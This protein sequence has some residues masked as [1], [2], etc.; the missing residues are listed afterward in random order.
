MRSN[1]GKIVKTKTGKSNLD[2][3]RSY[4]SGERAFTQVG[5]DQ[6]TEL[7][8]RKEGEEWEDSQGCKWIKKNGYKQR[9]SKKAQYILEQRCTV[10]NADVKWGNRLDHKVYPK[11]QRCYECN[12]EFEGILRNQGLYNDYELFKVINNKLAQLKDFKDK[13]IDSINFLENHKVQPKDPQFFNE[14]GSNEIWIDDTDRIEIVLKDLR[15]DLEKT[16]EAINLESSELSKLNYNT[17]LDPKIKLLTLKKI[18]E[19]EDT[20]NG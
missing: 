3:V 19:K 6:N 13:I 12:I 9:V 15:S 10:C 2:I 5:Y 14:D 1:T 20:Q 16:N 11:T 8:K 7:N 17:N 18:K 4:M